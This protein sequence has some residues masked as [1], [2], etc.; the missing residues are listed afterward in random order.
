MLKATLLVSAVMLF[1]SGFVE[2]MSTK[3]LGYRE[4]KRFRA[5]S[6]ISTGIWRN[7]GVT[8][9][10]SARDS[11]LAV[12]QLNADYDVESMLGYCR[13]HFLY[14]VRL[15]EM[16]QLDEENISSRAMKAF[17]RRNVKKI[18]ADVQASEEQ[19]KKL[20][21]VTCFD[22]SWRN[23]LKI[24]D[25]VLGNSEKKWSMG[26]SHYYS[27]EEAYLILHMHPYFVFWGKLAGNSEKYVNMIAGALNAIVHDG[28]AIT[29]REHFDRRNVLKA[30]VEDYFDKFIL[31]KD[32]RR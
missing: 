5:F 10:Y 16:P 25:S 27:I 15:N 28:A 9:E 13:S 18:Q 31:N 4:L 17:Y 7:G 14:S 23:C 21:F 8:G 6:E 24:F 29:L 30:V 19:A 20:A 1:C 26:L 11:S 2:G 12:A 22:I 3:I 32:T